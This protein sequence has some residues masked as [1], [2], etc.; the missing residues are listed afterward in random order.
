LGLALLASGGDGQKSEN[1]PE[2]ST[3]EASFI[4]GEH[5]SAAKF[6]SNRNSF[7]IVVL[8]FSSLSTRGH[9]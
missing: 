4:S 2:R 6:K 5:Q 8:L 9:R 3:A 1:R 7:E